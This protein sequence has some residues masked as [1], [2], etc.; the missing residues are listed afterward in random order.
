MLIKDAKYWRQKGK[1]DRAQHKNYKKPHGILSFLFTWTVPRMK[2]V[3]LD[4]DAYYLGWT[5]SA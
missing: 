5:R 4:N 1:A 2:K 3:R